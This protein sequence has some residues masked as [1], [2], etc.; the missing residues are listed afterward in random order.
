[1]TKEEL[2]AQTDGT[3]E[4]RGIQVREVVNGFVIVATRTFIDATTRTTRFSLNSEGIA[5]GTDDLLAAMERFFRT[6]DP[7][8]PSA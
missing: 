8:P 4:Q 7:T 6:G 5:K 3:I 2:A 1:M